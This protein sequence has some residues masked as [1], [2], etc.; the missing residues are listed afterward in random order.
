MADGVNIHVDA[1]AFGS[2]IRN[3][4]ALGGET[5]NVLSRAVDEL[6]SLAEQTEGQIR[7]RAMENSETVEQA[8]RA[9]FAGIAASTASMEIARGTLMA[10]EAENADRIRQVFH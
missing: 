6:R 7:D 1:N 5:D 2:W 4:E 9:F 8:R 10:Y 3:Y